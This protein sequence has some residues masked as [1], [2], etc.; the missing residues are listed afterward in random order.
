MLE[1]IGVAV[2]VL[3]LV[4]DT[5]LAAL[6]RHAAEREARAIER[7]RHATVRIQGIETLSD[8]VGS[9]LGALKTWNP[10][11]F[12]DADEDDDLDFLADDE[13]DDSHSSSAT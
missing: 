6:G 5:R 3:L 13:S 11:L 10:A 12:E 7:A 8:Q 4:I 9:I 2:V 1:A